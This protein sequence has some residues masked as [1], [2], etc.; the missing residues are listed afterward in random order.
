MYQARIRIGQQPS[1]SFTKVLNITEALATK[2]YAI[3]DL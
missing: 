2:S 1:K 3:K